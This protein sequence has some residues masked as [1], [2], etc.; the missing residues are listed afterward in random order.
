MLLLK[1]MLSFLWY[2][3][4][5]TS[6]LMALRNFIS[7]GLEAV[8]PKKKAVKLQVGLTY[9]LFFNIIFTLWGLV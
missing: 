3:R 4:F 7:P 1:D 8:Y 9:N 5:P 6:S 2:L